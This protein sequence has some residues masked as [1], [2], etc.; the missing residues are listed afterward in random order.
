MTFARLK[1]ILAAAALIAWLAWLALAVANKGT[2]QIVSPAQLAAATHLVVAT[3][4]AN[5]TGEV[6]TKVTV[7][8]ILRGPA[9]D[10]IA[11]EIDIERLDKAVTPLPVNDS[12]RIAAGEYVIPLMKTP[13]GYR[14]AGLPR[15]P[16]FEGHTPD[17][18]LVYPWTDD[19]KAQ[20]RKLGVMKE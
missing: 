13:I 2:V 15:S 5:D 19:V 14:I 6:L 8:R 4:K 9:D 18:P 16:G 20:L 1:L 3:V 10:P 17:Q 12:R 11:G 7:T